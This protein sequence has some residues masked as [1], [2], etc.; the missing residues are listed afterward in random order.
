MRD[1]LSTEVGRTILTNASSQVLFGQHPQALD[2]LSEAFALSEGERSYLGSC[3]KGQGL[4]CVGA[5][6]ATLQ[7]VASD[8]ED[9]LV[10][11][12]PSELEEE[13]ER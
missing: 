13:D 10:T 12:D 11:T 9:L 3:S 5:E 4:L 1:A 2:A 6:R 7:V 8:A